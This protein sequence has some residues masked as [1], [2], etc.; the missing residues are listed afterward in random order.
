LL[1]WSSGEGERR[2]LFRVSEERELLD[3]DDA[4][5]AL[6]GAV[7][8]VHPLT[9][10]GEETARWSAVFADYEVLPPFPQLGRDVHEL[11]PAEGPQRDLR[12]L[13]GK[14]IAAATLVGTLERLG[15]TRG[16][17]QDA[18]IVSEH[19]KGFPGA[20]VTAIVRYGGVP[21]GYMLDWDDQ[22]VEGCVFLQGL[23]APHECV[24]VS[25]DR[26]LQLADVDPVVVSEV[27]RDLAA[28]E[29]KA[30]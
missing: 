16:V 20:G 24:W 21:A 19:S 10:T 4:L 5:V 9:L 17:P 8:I 1:L 12:R 15:W 7:R 29:G 26:G 18:G 25:P 2:V 13:E 6:P 30:R 22:E 11:T 14:R 3:A 23:L 28:L 27:L